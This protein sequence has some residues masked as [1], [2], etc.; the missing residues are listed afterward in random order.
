MNKKF[1]YIIVG[2][3]LAG[4]VLAHTLLKEGKSVLI[5]DEGMEHAA[6]AIAAG[7]YNPVVFKRLVKS[8]LADELIPCMDVFYKDAEQLLNKQFYFKKQIVKLFADEAEKAFW[9]K[10]AQEEV[11]SY[12]SK[13]TEP[14]FLNEWID[15]PYGSA[16]VTAAGNLDTRIFLNAF[17][18]YFIQKDCILQDKFEY[19]D[20][21]ILEKG[22]RYRNFD[23]DKLIFCEGHKTT[24]NPYFKWLPFKLTKGEVIIIKL[25]GE[26]SIPT[27]KV[28]NKG[29][30][31]LP[32]GNNT[33]KVGATYEWQDLSEQPTEKG[34]LYLI[35]KLQKVIHVPFEI[36]GHEA[37]IRPTVLDRR[38]LIG[39]HP[40]HAS[41]AIFNGMGTKG[42][43]LAPYFAQQFSSFLDNKLALSDEVN[44]SRY[45]SGRLRI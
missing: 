35:E 45:L 23:A 33:Y 25:T 29:V 11:G 9:L 7:L 15:N 41:I 36:I 21:A 1:N 17:R 12:L 39:L 6:S 43:M 37:G 20:L 28:I 13:T 34:R 4:T 40:E 8:W 2:Q 31:I 22:V 3:G 24:L 44:C 14:Y 16:E 18:N 30:F 5:I 42:V 10:K 32:L 38:P 19:A 27:E 26:T